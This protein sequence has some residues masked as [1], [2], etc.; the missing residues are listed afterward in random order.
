[1]SIVSN[2]PAV[3][4]CNNKSPKRLV[5]LPEICFGGCTPVAE[6]PKLEAKGRE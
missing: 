1:M 4:C 3:S 2:K 5:A 6:G